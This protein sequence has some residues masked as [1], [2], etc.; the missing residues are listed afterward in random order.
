[1]ITLMK[2]YYVINRVHRSAVQCQD[3]LNASA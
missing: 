2:L 3:T 1:M